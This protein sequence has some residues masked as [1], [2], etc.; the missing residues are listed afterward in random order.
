MSLKELMIT[1][2]QRVLT[3]LDNCLPPIT[4]QPYSLHQAMRYAVFNGGKRIRPILVYLTGLA[5][6]VVPEHLDTPAAAVEL[7]HSYSLVHDD[8]PAMDNDDLRRGQPTCHKVYGEATAILAGDALQTLAFYILSHP[9]PPELPPHQRIAMIEVLA[10]AT[11]S[12]GMAGGQALDIAATGH[13]QPNLGIAQLENIH[14]H[15][16]GALI[17]AAV[18]LGALSCP[19]L[20]SSTL[21]ALD[22]YAKCIGLAYQIQ[23]DILDLES[24]TQTLGK[25]QGSD[26]A[27]QK[28][29]YPSLLG[30]TESKTLAHTLIEEAIATLTDLSDKAQPLRDL[31]HF[32]LT[33]KY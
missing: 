19:H 7:I 27:H 21:N 13:S 2:Q 32:I 12:R 22:H 23:D 33:R 6:E 31:A 26:L 9:V 3:P 10:L 18:K 4:I 20:D 17:R 30:L 16:T 11:G 1:Y 29:T 15:K 25:P 28:L 14:I 8:L 5:L 24:P